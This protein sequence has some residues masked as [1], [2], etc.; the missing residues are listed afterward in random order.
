MNDISRTIGLTQTSVANEHGLDVSDEE[1][2]AQGSAKD[3]ALLLSYAWKNYPGI[4]QT[5]AGSTVPTH[6]IDGMLHVAKNTNPLVN[7]IPG[8]L[9]SKTGFTELAGGNVAVITSP[10]LEGPFAIVV[11]GSTYDGRFSDLEQLSRTT[12]EYVR[13]NR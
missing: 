6:S 5:T 3:M 13:E 12:L 7:N 4:F 1:S 11:L 10:G 2:G 8:L 9:A